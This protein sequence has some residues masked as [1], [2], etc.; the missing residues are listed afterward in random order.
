MPGEG[1][2]EK[3]NSPF[4]SVILF[5]NHR[6]SGYQHLSDRIGDVE[7]IAGGEQRVRRLIA[8]L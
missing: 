8:L 1:T 4:P 2:G 5:P 7:L 3:T 6:G